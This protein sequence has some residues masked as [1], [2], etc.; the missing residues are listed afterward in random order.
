MDGVYCTCV[1]RVPVCAPHVYVC[2][3]SVCVG[4]GGNEAQLLEETLERVLSPVRSSDYLYLSLGFS[5]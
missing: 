3:Y 2:V 1:V 5:Q 4:H